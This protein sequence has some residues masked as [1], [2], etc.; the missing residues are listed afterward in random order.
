MAKKKKSE[1]KV[2]VKSYAFQTKLT[3]SLPI[4]LS[5][6]CDSDVIVETGFTYLNGGLKFCFTLTATLSRKSELQEITSKTSL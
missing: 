2:I 6:S 4:C 5:C 3:K 1:K